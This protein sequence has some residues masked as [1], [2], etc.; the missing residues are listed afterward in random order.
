MAER[1]HSIAAREARGRAGSRGEPEISERGAEP[2]SVRRGRV[3]QDAEI[4]REA[5][6]AVRR[7]RVG[8]D[9]Q[10]ADPVSS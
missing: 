3:D 9:Q 6:P 2:A 5:R 10:E 1:Q 8:A 4:L 7:Q